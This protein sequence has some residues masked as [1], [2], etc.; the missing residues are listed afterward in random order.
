MEKGEERQIIAWL[1]HFHGIV[2][3]FRA[4]S[5]LCDAIDPAR[6]GDGR[7]IALSSMAQT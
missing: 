4:W 5:A 6:R 1:R 7:E 3:A 2:R